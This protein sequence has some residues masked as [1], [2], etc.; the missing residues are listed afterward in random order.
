M[1][2]LD[3][4][5][6]LI[7]GLIRLSGERNDN[8]IRCKEVTALL[9]YARCYVHGIHRGR[10]DMIDSTMVITVLVCLAVGAKLV[11]AYFGDKRSDRGGE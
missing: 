6:T 1:A 2:P 8:R 5:I 10:V 11:A 3:I 4:L 7:T 9:A